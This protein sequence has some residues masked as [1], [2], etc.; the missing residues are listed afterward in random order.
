MVSM[1]TGT[2]LALF[3]A[4]FVLIGFPVIFTFISVMSDNWKYLLYS[5]PGSFTAG[6]IGLVVTLQ[7][8]KKERT[9]VGR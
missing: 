3:V 4:L 7:H 2:K 5:L 8:I 9:I 6:F 1:K